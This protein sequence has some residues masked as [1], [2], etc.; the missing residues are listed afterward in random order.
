LDGLLTLIE[1]VTLTLLRIGGTWQTVAASAI[2]ALGVVPLL[3]KTLEYEGIG[4]VNFVWNLFSTILMFVI[5]M[6]SFAEKIT[7]L[8]TIGVILSLAGLGLIIMSDEQQ[9]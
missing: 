2:Y 9:K 6:Y 8:K 7:G 1:S 3:T 5:G 4:M